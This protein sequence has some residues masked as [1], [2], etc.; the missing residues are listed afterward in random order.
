MNSN[1]VI[2]LQEH[3]LF[4]HE[5]NFLPEINKRFSAVSK[6]V[7]DDNPIQPSHK[8]RGYGGVAWLWNKSLDR[9]IKPLEK[10]G[11]RV[12]AIQL[13]TTPRPTCLITTYMPARAGSVAEAIFREVM[14]E[15]HEL[16]EKY[17]SSH[18][19]IILGDI[20]ASLVKNPPLA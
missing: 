20:N 13:A 12:L 2:A 19:V 6:H 1:N 8:P 7:D 4:Q 11:N 9:I 15:L 16:Y 17:S 18:I 3:W 5:K 14:D 10:G